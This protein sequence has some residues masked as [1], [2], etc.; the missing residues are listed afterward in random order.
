MTIDRSI[1]SPNANERRGEGGIDTVVLH[2]TDLPSA[3]ESLA[4]LTDPARQVSAHY[5]IGEDGHVWALVA[6][7]RRAW[8]AGA[9]SWRGRGDLNSRSIGIELQNPGHSNGYRPFTEPQLEALTALL[10]G[11]LARHP[12]AARDLLAHSDLAPTRKQD[13][14]ELFPWARLAAAGI[15]LWPRPGA[16]PPAPGFDF[17]AGL[18][19]FGYDIGSDA[20]GLDAA[21]VAF[22]RR[23]AP[24]ELGQAPGP[25][26]RT[27]L[28]D[29][30]AQVAPA[31]PAPPPPGPQP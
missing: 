16:R 12:I 9:G 18:A 31:N 27:A 25:L 6:E 11:I 10:H 24:A 19:R 30:L 3:A 8:H 23:F 7:D 15:G 20:A 22:Q 28:A 5:L 14:G 17:A 21:T 1:T 4:I 2:Y 13:P 26:S 29:L